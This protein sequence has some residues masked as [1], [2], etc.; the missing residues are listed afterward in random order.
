MT[1]L[2]GVTLTRVKGKMRRSKGA[3]YAGTWANRF[4]QSGTG[5]FAVRCGAAAG[6]RDCVARVSLDS[7]EV[8]SQVAGCR[9]GR[10]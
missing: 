4:K 10:V 9:H 8:P 6:L 7:Q 3:V 2:A 1:Q 5:G